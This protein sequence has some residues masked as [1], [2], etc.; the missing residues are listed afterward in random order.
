MPVLK[1]AK[2][3]RFAQELAKGTPAAKAYVEAGYKPSS[4]NAATLKATQSISERV[5]ELLAEREKVHAQATAIAIE[6]AALTKEWVIE[7]L[8]E[9]AERAL[10]AIPAGENGTGEYQY[11]GS[12]ANRALELLGK[13]LGMFIDRKE[14]GKPGDFAGLSDDELDAIISGG[15][16]ANSGGDRGKAS[17]SGPA[18]VRG[19]SSDL[20]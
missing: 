12:V 4:G 10:Q 11:Q 8:R 9:N 6:K 19:K 2:H 16:A 7:R 1:N 3:E 20:H 17:P 13:E 15:E 5:A 14:V 18:R